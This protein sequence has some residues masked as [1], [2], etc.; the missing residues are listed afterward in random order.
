M[1]YWLPIRNILDSNIASQ[2]T[3]IKKMNIIPSFPVH[4]V[5]LI[6][7]DYHQPISK[8]Q[9]CTRDKGVKVQDLVNITKFLHF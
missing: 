8:S 5:N 2:Q 4:F 1:Y 7:I 3:G 6:L 9:N